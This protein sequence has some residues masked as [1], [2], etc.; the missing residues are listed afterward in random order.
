[1]LSMHGTVC[2]G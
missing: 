1:M 2:R